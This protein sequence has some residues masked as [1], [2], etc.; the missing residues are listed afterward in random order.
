MIEFEQK[1]IQPGEIFT[2]SDY[3][4]RGRLMNLCVTTVND[5][6]SISAR[7]VDDRPD[8]DGYYPRIFCFSQM[9]VSGQFIKW[10]GAIEK[11]SL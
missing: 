11:V 5:N 9:S 3:S 6:G 10:T 2:H 1:I 4:H 7:P 8:P